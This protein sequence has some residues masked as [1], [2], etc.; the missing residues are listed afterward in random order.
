MSSTWFP[1]CWLS[2]CSVKFWTPLPLPSPAP[3]CIAVTF[4]VQL[5]AGGCFKQV[6]YSTPE[7][8]KHTIEHFWCMMATTWV[9]NGCL[10]TVY[11]AGRIHI[12]YTKGTQVA[13]IGYTWGK[14]K[15]LIHRVHN[16]G[17]NRYTWGKP[18][19]QHL[20]GTLSAFIQTEK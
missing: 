9:H 5:W 15:W 16:N 11:E 1:N 12:R 10:P 7:T 13:Q 3:S 2:G 14:H 19:W 17:Y 18:M 20:R 8:P 4:I 6:S